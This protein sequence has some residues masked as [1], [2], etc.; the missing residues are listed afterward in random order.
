MEQLN[1]EMPLV[2]HCD[3]SSCGYNQDHN[4]HAKAITV[5]DSL[6]PGC[7]TFMNSKRHT[8]ERKRLAGVGA[9]KVSGCKYNDDFECFAE[10]I[11]VGLVE[12]IVKCQTFRPRT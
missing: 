6:S 7:D 1:V 11:T 2:K 8:K 9:C 4:C 12:G 10:G 5:G 3:V